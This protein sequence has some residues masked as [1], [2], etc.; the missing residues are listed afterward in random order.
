VRLSTS[1]LWKKMS[2][3]FFNVVTGEYIT[4]ILK[5]KVFVN[6]KEK[7][8]YLLCQHFEHTFN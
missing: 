4:F 1:V 3:T 5:L 2:T 6:L 7:L 8:N